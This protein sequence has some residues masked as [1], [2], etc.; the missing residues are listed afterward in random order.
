MEFKSKEEILEL[1]REKDYYL[2]MGA[3]KLAKM[4]GSSKSLIYECKEIIR[5]ENKDLNSE[6]KL[7]LEKSNQRYRDL[8][9]INSKDKRE[10]FRVLNA[11]EELDEHLINQ[12]EIIGKQLKI[13]EPVVSKNGTVALVQLS[14]THFNELV[15]LPNNTYDFYV[16]AKRMQKY[17]NEVKKYCSVNNV[18]KI[19]LGITGDL[20]N[21]DR[22]LDEKLSMS[23]NRTKATLLAVELIKYFIID[24]SIVAPID[25]AFVTGNESRVNDEWGMTDLVVSDNYD[26]LIFNMLRVLFKEHKNIRFI[27]SNPVETV[28]TVNG[29]NILMLHGTTLGMD[30]QKRVQQVIGKYS[31]KG[32]TIDYTIF[33]HIHF[34]NITDLYARSGSLV[35]NNTYS[36]YGI[37]LVTKA[38]QNV[39]FID[40]FGEIQNIRVEL[41]S[42]R[43]YE[44]YPIGDD[45]DAYNAKSSS[46]LYR[47]HN[48]I[49]I[50]I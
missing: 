26:V 40:Q 48:I 34:A 42:T 14:D 36:D 30:S 37:N 27:E 5:E 18:N 22:R 24:L 35:G 19:V 10:Y 9:R 50:V 6:S 39:H 11:L 45:I 44:G 3:G 1:F 17:A 29:K 32:V 49:E 8:N 15:D 41:D 7:K 2:N 4:F 20:I 23:T 33:G 16:A 12:L 46:K 28:L 38:S 25:V 43:G 47:E 13:P 21:S 31:A